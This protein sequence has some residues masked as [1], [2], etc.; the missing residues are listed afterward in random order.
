[1]IGNN[2]AE[3]FSNRENNVNINIFGIDIDSSNTEAQTGQVLTQPKKI[4]E[5]IKT[6]FILGYGLN[7]YKFQYKLSEIFKE[8]F[9]SYLPE[10]GREGL[11][12]NI[13]DLP[14]RIVIYESGKIELLEGKNGDLKEVVERFSSFFKSCRKSK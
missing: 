14:A 8:E 10:T 9:Y 12:V 5:V 6:A 3:I 1:M 7:L 13:M 11:Y 4:F 2:F